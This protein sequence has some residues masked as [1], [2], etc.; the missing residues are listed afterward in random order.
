MSTAIVK[1]KSCNGTG[2]VVFPEV[3]LLDGGMFPERQ[4]ECLSCGGGGSFK[5]KTDGGFDGYVEK[6]R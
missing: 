4:H 2:R 1:C 5:I 3:E 6:Q